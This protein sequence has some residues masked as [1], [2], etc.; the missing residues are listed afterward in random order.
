LFACICE[1]LDSLVAKLELFDEQRFYVA[2]ILSELLKQKTLIL[3]IFTSFY[4]SYFYLKPFTS[5]KMKTR[6]FLLAVASYFLSSISVDLLLRKVFKSKLSLE[7]W[8]QKHGLVIETEELTMIQLDWA[9]PE[10]ILT[11]TT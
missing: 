1:V 2:P 5:H 7:N 3:A 9:M 10:S 6:F 4:I 8:A 11:I